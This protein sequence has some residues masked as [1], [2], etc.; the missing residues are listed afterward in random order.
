MP[1]VELV[2]YVAS[3]LIVVSLMMTSLLRLRIV[4]SAG[5]LTFAL[6]AVLIGSLPVLVT[7]VAILAINAHQLARIWRDRAQ[8]A[9]FEVVEVDPS[10]PVLRRFVEFYSDDIAKFQPEFSG[11]RADHLAWMVLRNAVPVGAVLATRTDTASARLE[12]DYVV[13]AHRDFTPGSVLFG[14]SKA[15]A[16]AGVS[17]VTTRSTTQAHERYLERMGFRHD[18]DLWVREVP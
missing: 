3:A 15:F 16:T 13:N 11:V 1:A 4:N 14:E 17:Q 9:Y 18:G 5:S 8:D 7:N 6:Y 12:L 10:S 2:G